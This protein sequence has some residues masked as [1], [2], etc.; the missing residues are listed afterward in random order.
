M[1]GDTVY[2]GF[3]LSEMIKYAESQGKNVLAA[4]NTDFFSLKTRVPLGIVVENGVYKSSPEGRSAVIFDSYGN[5][6]ILETPDVS[7]T[8]NNGDKYVVLRNFNKNR[9]DTGGMYLFSS[10]FSEVSTRTASPGWFVKFRVLEGVP[11][12]SGTM[13]LEV[14]E[15]FASGALPAVPIGEGNLVLTAAEGGGYGGEFNKFAVGDIVTMTTACGDPALAAAEYAT[16]AGDLLVRGGGVCD[17]SNIEK[18]LREKAPRSALGIKAD[19]SLV[20]FVLDGRDSTRSVGLTLEELAAELVSLGCVSAVNFDGGGSSSI[21]VRVPGDANNTT[22]NKPSDGKERACATYILFVTDEFPDGLAHHLA[23]SGDGPVLLAGSELPLDIRATDAARYPVST[24]SDVVAVS[25]GLGFVEGLLYT[26]GASAGDDTVY[27]TSES[28]WARGYGTVHIIQNPTSLFLY[29]EGGKAE[30][31]EITAYPGVAMKLRGEATYYRKGVVSSATAYKYSLSGDIGA[32]DEGGLFIPSG[33]S[34]AGGSV[35][36]TA[37]DKKT[38]VKVSVFSF[39]DVTA[40]HWASPYIYSSVKRGLVAGTSAETFA[41]ELKMRRGDFILL[42]HKAAGRPKPTS[43]VSFGDVEL[44]DYYAEAL[45][46]GLETGVAAADSAGN[47][48]PKRQLTREE[49]FTFAYR[50]FHALNISMPDENM[51]IDLTACYEY[52]DIS[53]EALIPTASLENMGIVQGSE[54]LLSPRGTVSRAEMVTIF[55]KLLDYRGV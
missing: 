3:T 22:R 49:A 14:S 42:L 50:A 20:C 10:A 43:D 46:W 40:E 27:L 28:T 23:L 6:T 5:A 30:L 41:P 7:I 4:M 48:D 29:E 34:G 24:P 38:T 16:G 53:G 18:E 44:T 37:G 19:G 9:E 35:T 51:T 2:G 17:L 25:G 21:G 13:T 8:L 52:P 47:F 11:T 12:V 32:I 1:N 36:V 54:G 31:S 39:D 15:L 26:A 55:T 33:K 45:A